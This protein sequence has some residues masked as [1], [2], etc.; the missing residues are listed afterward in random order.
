LRRLKSVQ[1]GKNPPWGMV[2]TTM[3]ITGREGE[4][5]VSPSP[6]FSA[7]ALTGPSYNTAAESFVMSPRRAGLFFSDKTPFQNLQSYNLDYFNILRY[8]MKI[9]EK[10]SPP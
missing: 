8:T 5:T 6:F 9:L 4:E 2:A 3:V 1:T 7:I 10:F